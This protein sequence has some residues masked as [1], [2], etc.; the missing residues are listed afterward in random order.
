MNILADN[1]LFNKKSNKKGFYSRIVYNNEYIKTKIS[2]YNENFHGNKKLTKDEYYGHSI[3]LLEPISE[4]EN[5]HYPQTFL[6]EF[7]KIH[8]G[9]N[10]NPLFNELVQVIDWFHDDDRSNN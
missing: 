10:I 1:V 5:K 2:P 6:G 4:E 7:F 3:L 8:S 9:N